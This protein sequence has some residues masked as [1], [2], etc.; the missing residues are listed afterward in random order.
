MSFNEVI[1]KGGLGNQLFG[2]LFAYKILLSKKKVHLNLK[3][4]AFSKRKDR[5]FVLDKLFPEIFE[6]FENSDSYL[7]YLRFLYAKL[8]ERFYRDNKLDGLSLEKEFS[9]NYWPNCFIHTGYF[10]KISNS[11]LDMESLELLMSNLKPY[12]G[13]AKSQFLAAH[14]RRGD[15]LLKKHTMHGLIAEEYIIKEL[16]HH[17][18]R[19]SF[20][21]I[22]IFTDSPELVEINNYRNLHSNVVFDKGGNSVEVL[23]RMLNHKGLVASNSSFSLWAGLLGNIKYFS[24]PYFWMPNVKSSIL[25]LNHIRRYTCEI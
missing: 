12:L 18:S 5:K 24:I 11:D 20:E 22:T 1:I 17:L 8:F 14:I 15:Y 19:Q 6:I 21:G 4:Y 16:K 9:I 7:S 10:Q 3:N 23:K 2:L 25:G 13:E